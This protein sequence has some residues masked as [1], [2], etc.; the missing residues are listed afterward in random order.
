MSKGGSFGSFPLNPSILLHY[1]KNLYFWICLQK[2]SF[3]ISLLEKLLQPVTFLKMLL[4]QSF[5]YPFLLSF[6]VILFKV[7]SVRFNK[8]LW[9]HSDSWMLLCTKL[10]IQIFDTMACGNVGTASDCQIMSYSHVDLKMNEHLSLDLE[11]KTPH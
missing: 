8:S 3:R 5:P 4:L 9:N 6:F 10:K 11:N 7:F 2:L 1:T